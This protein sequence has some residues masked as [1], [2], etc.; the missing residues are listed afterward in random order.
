M[1]TKYALKTNDHCNFG[2]YLTQR[3][4]ISAKRG[5]ARVFESADEAKNHLLSIREKVQHFK[6]KWYVV[7]VE[8][9]YSIKEVTGTTT[10][11]NY[12]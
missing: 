6:T 8:T 12:V 1:A 7:E 5:S 9:K 11:V 3:N 10:E 2:Y 4:C